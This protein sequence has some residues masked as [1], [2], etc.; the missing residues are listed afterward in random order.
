MPTTV[1]DLLNSEVNRLNERK[2]AIDE[3][4][5]ERRRV[6]FFNSS[7]VERQKAYNNIYLVIVVMMFIVVIIKMVYQIGIVPD[8]ILDIL[9]ALVISAGLIYCIILYDDI[10][11]RNNMDFSRFDL[12]K[13]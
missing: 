2:T 12:G 13:K 10:M 7:A 3:A 4:E 6:A 9:T 11:R 8:A 5:E 1:E